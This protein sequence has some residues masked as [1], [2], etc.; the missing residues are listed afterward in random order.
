[1]TKNK[2][3]LST[4]SV[5]SGIFFLFFITAYIKNDIKLPELLIDPEKD[6]INFHE[7]FYKVVNLG[8]KRMI[9][10]LLW[11]HTLL[12]GDLNHIKD[13]NS[14]SWMF[15][16]FK[17][18]SLIDPL[19]YENYFLGGQ[20]L[21]VVKDD[22]KGSNFLFHRGLKLFPN[23]L[24]LNFNL[25][26]NYLFYEKNTK[27]GIIYWKKILQ[28]ADISKTKP[29]LPIRIMGFLKNQ[30][31]KKWG[32]EILKDLALKNKGTPIGDAF[33]KKLKHLLNN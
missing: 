23:D 14:F 6:E 33:E 30:N 10:S 31:D 26:F 29:L 3:I 25:G 28:N 13:K 21:G 5:Y 2:N 4:L 16:R 24:E 8:Q 27:K 18:I 22:V 11:T 20:Y 12:F 19:F 1:M 9:S 7:D 32:I 17:G 15:Y